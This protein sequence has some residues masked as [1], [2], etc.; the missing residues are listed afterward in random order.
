MSDGNREDYYEEMEWRL[1]YDESPNNK[2]LQGGEGKR[3]IHRLKV[4]AHDIKAI[5]FPDED[6]KSCH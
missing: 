4:S 2:H 1:V 3:S 6:T 5:I